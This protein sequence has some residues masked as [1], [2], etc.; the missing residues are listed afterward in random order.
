MSPTKQKDWEKEYSEVFDE[1]FGLENSPDGEEECLLIRD[2]DDFITDAIPMKSE[3]KA[4]SEYISS[5]LQEQRAEFEKC[6]PK[7]MGKCNETG[8]D[9]ITQYVDGFNACLDSLK[10][11]YKKIILKEK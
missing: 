2:G 6:F 7:S 4:M 9:M 3:K 8:H 1:I 5:L 11:N 10:A